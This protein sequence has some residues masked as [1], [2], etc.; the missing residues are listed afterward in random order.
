MPIP[1]VVLKLMMIWTQTYVGDKKMKKLIAA[2]SSKMATV[3]NETT[4]IV[5]LEVQG[6]SRNDDHFLMAGPGSQAYQ[7]Q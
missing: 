6:K 5:D 4:T 3:I 2:T 7:G 1:M